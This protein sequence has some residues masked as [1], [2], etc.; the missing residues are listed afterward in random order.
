MRKLLTSYQQAAFGD[1][2]ASVPL[3]AL[4][5]QCLM[6]HPATLINVGHRACAGGNGS[7][8]QV[9][10]TGV[11]VPSESTYG[12]DDP[13]VECRRVSDTVRGVTCA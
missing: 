9:G 1:I 8:A 2:W 5:L 13:P 3:E 7:Y 6:P 11:H 12:D 10:S 4:G